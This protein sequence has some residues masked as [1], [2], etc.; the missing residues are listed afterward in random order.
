MKVYLK[1]TT[2]E[3]KEEGM[4]GLRC[5]CDLENVSIIDKMQVPHS[6]IKALEMPNYEV[7]LFMELYRKGVLEENSKQTKEPDF[8]EQAREAGVQV[9][10]FDTLDDFIAH[11][12]GGKKR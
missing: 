7:E 10:E 3:T 9:V 4:H 5:G 6:T 1:M 2:I 8:V 12:M 11:I